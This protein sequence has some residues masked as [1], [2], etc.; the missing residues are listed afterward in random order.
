[1]SSRP[2]QSPSRGGAARPAARPAGRREPAGFV[3]PWEHGS[4]LYRRMVLTGSGL[5]LVGIVLSVVGSATHRLP[6]SQAALVVLGLGVLVHLAA[7][8]V[9]FRQ[10]ARRQGGQPRG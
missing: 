5:F 2:R 3:S 7:Q 4:S 8:M 10:A 9:R 1:M 6:L